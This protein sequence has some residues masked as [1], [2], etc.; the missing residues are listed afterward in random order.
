[1]VLIRF[2]DDIDPNQFV[3]KVFEHLTQV[4][5]KPR[6]RY[7]NRILPIEKTC[8]VSDESIMATISPAIERVFRTQNESNR[9]F[10]FRVDLKARNNEK[11]N[12]DDMKRN[13][14]SKVGRG[15]FVDLK[16]PNKVLLVEVFGKA[17]GVAVIDFDIMDTFKGFNIRSVSDTFGEP[18]PPHPDELKAK[19]ISNKPST[20]ASSS[21]PAPE[22]KSNEDG[23]S[24]S[25]SDMDLDEKL[26]GELEENG[27]SSASAPAVDDDDDSDS[28]SGGI[29]LF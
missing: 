17:A 12:K 28:D 13:L 21:S 1:M 4:V 3:I 5:K 26:N 24:A 8:F 16:A 14:V 15:H 9:P 19:K 23:E 27:N 29:S 10:K 11:L 7:S 18:L 22:N 25:T 2:M 6:T 20:E